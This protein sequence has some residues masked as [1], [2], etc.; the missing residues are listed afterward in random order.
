[1]PAQ[2]GEAMGTPGLASPSDIR[3]FIEGYFKVWEGT[4]EDQILSFYA[5]TVLVEIAGISVKGKSALRDHFVR[6]FIAAFPGN[7]HVVKDMIFGKDVVVV[8][9]S[10]EADHSGPFVG[11]PATGVTVKVPGCGVYEFD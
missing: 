1:M 4:D 5:E 10:F 6:P 11:R 9:F 7:R 2:E 8:E 3:A